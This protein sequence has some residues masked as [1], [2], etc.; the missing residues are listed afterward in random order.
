M[1]NAQV[2]S[3]AVATGMPEWMQNMQNANSD[4]DRNN[5]DR[6]PS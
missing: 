2:L 3:S 1:R 5:H 4:L 6:Q